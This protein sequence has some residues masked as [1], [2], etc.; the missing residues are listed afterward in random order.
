MVCGFF[1]AAGPQF[2]FKLC[3]QTHDGVW[4]KCHWTGLA[5]IGVGSLI[6]LIGATLLFFASP[7]VRLGL[8]V[9]GCLAGVLALLYP[10]ILIGGCGN[11]TMACRVVTFP[12]I[13]VFSILV[14]AG[15][16]LNGIYLFLKEF[17]K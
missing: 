14:I 11:E 3:P 15:M 10:T 6:A 16:A 5:E 9:A 1:I 13:I 12:A 17:K 2:L 4:M 8:S 7:K